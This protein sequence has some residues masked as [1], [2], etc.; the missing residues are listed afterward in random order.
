MKKLISLYIILLL[1]ITIA[2]GQFPTNKP[3]IT[4]PITTTQYSSIDFFKDQ[5]KLFCWNGPISTLKS[6]RAIDDI[7]LMSYNDLSLGQARIISYPKGGLSIWESIIKPIHGLEPQHREVRKIALDPEVQN[8][9]YIYAFFVEA[10]NLVP[11]WDPG[12][13]NAKEPKLPCPVYVYKRTSNKWVLI[14]KSDVKDFNDLAELE[15]D[16]VVGDK[17]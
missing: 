16:T 1:T 14:K 7:P 10:K 13:P 17:K 9:Y 2:C 4:F 15:F 3:D 12:D 6:H 11:F 8:Q 5:K